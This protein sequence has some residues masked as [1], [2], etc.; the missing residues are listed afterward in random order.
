MRILI[1]FLV[2][3]LLGIILV[4]VWSIGLGWLLS[5][6]VPFSLFEGSFMV[7]AATVIV[8]YIISRVTSSPL[9]SEDEDEDEDF[10]ADEIDEALGYKIPSSRF[11]ESEETKTWEAYF[12]YGLANN[13]NLE[14]ER[15][16]RATGRMN[17]TQVQ[18][19]SIRL[20]DMIVSLL[21]RR[22]ARKRLALTVAELKKHM[23]SQGQKPYDD[24]ILMLATKAA[25]IGLTMP[26]H[27]SIV[28]DKLWDKLMMD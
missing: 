14:F 8:A 28:H 3:S 23:E 7:M 27:A 9:Y 6:I 10:D 25:N 24:D 4:L 18:E 21:K 13:I 16:P 1:V 20:A 15:N 22:S 26:I 19:L 11:Y 5:H 2:V 17:E 12:R